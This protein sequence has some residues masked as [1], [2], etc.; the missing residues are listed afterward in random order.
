MKFLLLHFIFIVCLDAAAQQPVVINTNSEKDFIPEGIAIDNKTGIMYVSSINRHKIISID[1]KGKVRDFIKPD[2]DGF[3]EGLGLKIDKRRNWLWGLSVLKEGNVYHSKVHAFDLE[4]G[5]KKQEYSIHDTTVKAPVQ[6]VWKFWSE[7]QHIQQW[8]NASDD[9][10]TPHVENDLRVGG[11]FSARMEAKDGSYGFD[12]GG[13]YDSV[14]DNEHIAYT[15]GDGRK[16][17]ISFTPQGNETRVVETFDAET[18]HPI[19]MQRT[20]WQ[21]ILDNFKKYTEA[22]LQ[23]G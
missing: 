21:S 18:T 15:L 8:N 23:E 2:Q 4:T 5:E 20:G 12:F 16:V 19:D 11:K 7:P 13:V 17:D 1:I 14:K 3:K 10:H 9:W 6:K 22:S